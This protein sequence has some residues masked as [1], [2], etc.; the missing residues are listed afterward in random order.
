[1]ALTKKSQ[2]K[3]MELAMHHLSLTGVIAWVVSIFMLILL[4][5]YTHAEEPQQLTALQFDIV[6]IRLTVDP[7]TLTVPKNIA[8]QL[9]TAL[10]VPDGSGPE[11]AQALAAF[12][13]GAVVEAELRGPAITP[14]TLT[15]KP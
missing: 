14:T 5:L 6:G 11:V 12:A 8:T 7:P 3:T 2:S 15:V 9:N 4:P 13:Q 1:M 10:V